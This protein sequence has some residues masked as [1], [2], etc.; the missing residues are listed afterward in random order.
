M[1]VIIFSGKHLNL[2]PA[3]EP[4][5]VCWVRMVQYV[6]HVCFYFAADKSQNDRK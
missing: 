3:V 5:D 6:K 4:V 2:K 1:N